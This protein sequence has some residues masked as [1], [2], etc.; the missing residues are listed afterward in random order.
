[1]RQFDCPQC[2]APVLFAT[3]GAV[4]A[5]CQH[6]QTMAVRRDTVLESIGTMAEL[7]PDNTPLQIGAKGVHQGRSFRLLGRMRVGW[8][9]GTWNEWY[10]DLGEG[11]NGWVA[12]AQG[13]FM[14]SEGVPVTPDLAAAVP[15][16]K[17]GKAYTIGN[18]SYQVTDVKRARMVA[19]EGELPFV[20][21][22]NDEWTTVDL[23]GPGRK[24][25]GA[26]SQQG[27]ARLYL[28]VSA[29]PEEITWE[30]LRPVPGWKG[31]P[32]PVEKNKT[33]SIGCP[34]CGGVITLRAAGQTI[35]LVCGHCG[36]LLDTAG[37]KA[38]VAQKIQAEAKLEHPLLP[39]GTRGV[40]RGVE[41]EIL[42]CL[43]RQDTDS[44]W[45]EILLY[46]PWSGFAWLTEWNGHWNYIRRVL[47]T[48]IAVAGS[49]SLN[50]KR[51]RLFASSE[52]TVVQVAGE[53]YWQVRIGEVATVSDFI[54]PP[55]VLSSEQYPDL[56]EITWSEGEY[57]LADE[58]GA[59]FKISNL[60]RAEGPY[61]NQPNPWEARWPTIKRYALIAAAVLIGVQ[62]LSLRGAARSQVFDQDYVYQKPVATL[63]TGAATPEAANPPLITPSFDLKGGQSP[64]RIEAK[65]AVDNAW[66]ALDADL[67]NDTTG[68]TYPA[69]ISVEYYH[70]YDDGDWSEGKQDADADLPA[71]PPGRYHLSIRPEADPSITRMPFHVSLQRGGLFWSNFFLCV[72]GILIG[73]VWIY[74]RHRMFE[75]KRWSQSDYTP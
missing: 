28:G 16:M 44:R 18:D 37:K 3:P 69:E 49:P 65:A 51:F 72:L 12:E 42:G 67:V 32:V 58:V 5:V 57:L 36:T 9:D 38:F 23:S 7:P 35:S 11:R 19:G 68:Q 62:F 43:K 25:A 46:N 6:C 70:G 1:M 66:L 4:F 55:L 13:F 54:A 63:P 24:F 75:A 2:G 34:A 21:K 20:A 8:D 15:K 27:Q 41:W 22:P 71:V 33:D 31:E 39:L 56:Q 29:Q 73:P 50:G 17:P 10:A 53:F 30:G 14:I 59:A 26:E 60:P 52:A 61:L 47:E 64:A 48:P 45:N 40:L 74:V